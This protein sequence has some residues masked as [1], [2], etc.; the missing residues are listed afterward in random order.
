[1]RTLER[2]MDAVGAVCLA[3]MLFIVMYG[4]LVRY[5][6]KGATYFTVPI[7]E[8]VQVLVV[9]LLLAGLQHEGRHVTVN[10]LT[11]R[12]K[13]QFGK[14]LKGIALFVAGLC[15]LFLSGVLCYLVWVGRTWTYMGLFSY[16]LLALFIPSAFGFL[17]WT[18]EIVIQSR[19]FFGEV[20][21]RKHVKSG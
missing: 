3:V 13:G 14:L 12:G 5:F 8:Y 17:L 2:I 21:Q 19:D 16:P 6:L 11:E 18:V 20:R 10:V 7:T 1:M 15:A 9:L 4:V